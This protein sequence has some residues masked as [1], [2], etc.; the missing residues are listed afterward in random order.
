M[1]EGKKVPVANIYSVFR[2]TNF[3]LQFFGIFYFF[4]ARLKTRRM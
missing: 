4:N 1:S 2:N 3:F